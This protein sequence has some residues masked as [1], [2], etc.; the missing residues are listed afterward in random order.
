[1]DIN[2]LDLMSYHKEN[3][4]KITIVTAMKSFEIPYG[5]IELGALG[6][7]KEIEEKPCYELLVNTGC[8]VMNEEVRAYIPK[9][10]YFDMTDLIKLLRQN[11][12]RIGA[13][14]IMSSNWLDMG[15]F[16]EMKNMM[17]RLI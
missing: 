15:E 12:E 3:N 4:N 1:M 8:Y 17:E 13:Y 2:Y 9:N 7:V 14:P 5:V 10:Q 16:R 6:S 11:K